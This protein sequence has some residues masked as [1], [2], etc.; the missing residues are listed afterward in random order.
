MNERINKETLDNY[1]KKEK[2]IISELL[3]VSQSK[4]TYHDVKNC[5]ESKFKEN[6]ER[7]KNKF[8]FCQNN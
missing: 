7:D 8:R 1:L 5:L 2:Q 3:L 4:C 6:K